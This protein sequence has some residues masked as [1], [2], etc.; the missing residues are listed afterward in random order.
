MCLFQSLSLSGRRLLFCHIANTRRCF[1]KFTYY[2]LRPGDSRISQM[3]PN[4]T[5]A[6]SW[7]RF[8]SAHFPVGLLISLGNG[9]YLSLKARISLSFLFFSPCAVIF[10]YQVHMVKTAIHRLG[11]FRRAVATADSEEE[12]WSGNAHLSVC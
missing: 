1:P 7:A 12:R 10:C 9:D 5:S 4:M 2:V 8:I 3:V 11:K 6:V